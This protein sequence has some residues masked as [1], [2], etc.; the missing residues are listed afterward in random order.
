VTLVAF[1]L[2]G[3]LVANQ[4]NKKKSVEFEDKSLY[5]KLLA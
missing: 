1:L 5:E 2:G 3:A 4:V